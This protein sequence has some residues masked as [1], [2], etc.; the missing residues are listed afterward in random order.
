VEAVSGHESVT[1]ILGP[2]S[3]SAQDDRADEPQ[4]EFW[5]R[6]VLTEPFL[7]ARLTLEAE[8]RSQAESVAVELGIRAA[9]LAVDQ[10][11]A[12]RAQGLFCRARGKSSMT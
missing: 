6:F 3:A 4:S 12:N 5:A 2:V 10:A 11:D 8:T 9:E 1:G 7:S